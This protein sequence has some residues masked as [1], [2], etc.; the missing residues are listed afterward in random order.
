MEVT[1]RPMEAADAAII[2][3]NAREADR[4]EFAALGYLTMDQVMLTALLG[5]R[6]ALVGCA[7]G[8]P[9]VAWGV[10][11]RDALAGLGTPWLVSTPLVVR[12]TPAFLRR[13]SH[14]VTL[15]RH[16]FARLE[17]V[18]HAENRLAIRWL[19]W[20]GFT[21]EAETKPVGVNGEPFRRFWIEGHV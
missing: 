21:V 2:A 4:R 7:D 3:R 6:E 10:V 1:I 8:E 19:G 13:C 5:D 11:E 20:L 18:V 17:N 15:W 14:Y 9:A 12:H 16:R